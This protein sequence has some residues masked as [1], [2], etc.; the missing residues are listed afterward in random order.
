[1]R[2][3][4]PRSGGN[5]QQS[6]DL[7]ALFNDGKEGHADWTPNE[8]TMLRVIH[9]KKVN[10]QGQP[11]AY[12]L[13]PVR[14]GTARHFGG[15]YEECTLHDFYVTRSPHADGRTDDELDFKLLPKHYVNDESIVDT[16]VVLWYISSMHHEP[17]SEDGRFIQDSG[18]GDY[19]WRGV[20]PVMWGGFDLVPHNFMNGTP[21]YPYAIQP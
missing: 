7:H 18:S 21:L 9:T 11:I 20:T 17:R 4:S 12:D 5:P 8:F 6:Q 16:D 15:E 10:Y 14:S 2:H 13:M 1:M 19:R 3:K